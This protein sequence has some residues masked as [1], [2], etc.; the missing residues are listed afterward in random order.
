MHFISSILCGSSFIF[1]VFGNE[2]SENV[3]PWQ[4]SQAG[5]CQSQNSEPQIQDILSL[6]QMPEMYHF[7]R[8]GVICYESGVPK[9]CRR[10]RLR[11]SR[12]IRSGPRMSC[13][14]LKLDSQGPL[15]CSWRQVDRNPHL[16]FVAPVALLCPPRLMLTRPG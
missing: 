3:V 12:G 4:N 2:E 16:P 8:V 9:S 7:P 10:Q 14:T 13:F 5:E 11:G 1:K 6:P 15:R